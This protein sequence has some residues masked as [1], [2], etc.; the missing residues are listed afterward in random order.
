MSGGGMKERR[1]GVAI[2]PLC[3]EEAWEVP[4]LQGETCAPLLS[5]LFLPI[6]EEQMYM[7]VM[8]GRRGGSAVWPP[9]KEELAAPSLSV[10]ASFLPLCVLLMAVR[11]RRR[12]AWHL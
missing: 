3:E 11:E 2:S 7:Y 9:G 12:Q 10:K 1:R 5:C 6:V 8:V 4:S